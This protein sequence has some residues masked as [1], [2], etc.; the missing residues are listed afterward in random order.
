MTTIDR[1]IAQ[2]MA[3]ASLLLITAGSAFA[4]DWPMWRYDAYRSSNS[5]DSLPDDMTLLWSRRLPKP[6]PAW[7]P[8]QGK[9]QFDASYQPIILGKRLIVPSMISDS[10]TA[11]DTTTGESRWRF[12]ADGPVR[13]APVG[14]EGKVWFASDDGCLYCLDAETGELRWKHRGAPASNRILGNDRMISAWPARGA[15][16]LRAGTIYYAAGIWPFMGTFLYAL[17][18]ETGEEVWCNSGSGSTFQTQQHSSPAFSGVAPQGY[19]VATE[20][21]LL[22]SGGRT[23]PAGYDRATGAFLH[24]DVSSRTFGKDAGGFDVMATDRW[25]YNRD[26]MFETESG[27]LRYRIRPSVLTPEGLF[28]REGKLLRLIGYDPVQETYTDRKGNEKTREQVQPIWEHELDAPITRIHFQAGEHLYAEGKDGGLYALSV[29]KRKPQV[30]WQSRIEG[31]PWTMLAGDDKLVVVTHGGALHC[32]GQGDGDDPRTYEATEPTIPEDIAQGDG[33]DQLDDLL[34]SELPREGYALVLGAN[35][36]GLIAALL[37]HSDYHTLVLDTRT[38]DVDNLRRR[39]DDAG[40]YGHRLHVLPDDIFSAALPPYFADLVLVPEVDFQDRLYAEPLVER[41]YETLRPYGGRALFLGDAQALQPRIADA[42]AAEL[43]SSVRIAP[44]EN[45]IELVRVGALAGAGTWTH[46]Y[47]D[48]ANSVVS[49]DTRVRAPLGLLWFGGPSNQEILPRH[50]HGPTPQVVGGRLFIE[51]P[52]V[53]RAV[54]VYTGRRLWEKKMPGIGRHYDYTSHEPGANAI[55]SNYVSVSDGVYIVQDKTCSR[56]DPATGTTVRTFQLPPDPETG[57]IPDWGYIAVVDD[58]LLAGARPMSFWTP[59][60]D[61]EEFRHV[62]VE[63]V[64]EVVA[65]MGKLQNFNILAK[66]DGEEN[67]DFLVKNLNRLLEEEDLASIL[68]ADLVK[69]KG[70][71][72]KHGQKTNR[73]RHEIQRVV[74]SEQPDRLE[75]LKE[76]NR[77]LLQHVYPLPRKDKP[78]IGKFNL[79]RTA[80]KRLIVMNRHDGQVLWEFDADHALRHNAI[81]AGGGKVFCIDRLPD[82][83]IDSLKRRGLDVPKDARVIALDLADGREVWSTWENVFGTWLGYSAEHDVLIQAGAKGRDRLHDEVGRGMVAYDA[84]TGNELWSDPRE[85]GGPVMLYHDTIITQEKAISLKT[86]QLIRRRHPLTGEAVDWKYNRHYGCATAIGSEHLI[87]FRS[88]A[89]GFFDLTNNGG[90]GNIGGFKAGCTS[91]L[92]VA[93]G[94]LNAPDYTRTCT[95][96]YQNQASL[97]LVHDPSVEVWTFSDL[98]R[99]ESRVK[100]LGLNLG[101]PGDRMSDEGTLWLDLPSTG[102]SSPDVPVTVQPENVHWYRHHA[103]RFYGQVPAW[104]VA[105]GVEGAESF[106]ITL[107]PENDAPQTYTVRLLF[108]EPDPA[109]KVG[110]RIFHVDVMSERR[111]SNVDILDLADAPRRGIAL[112][113]PEL[114]LGTTLRIEL[115]SAEGSDR[116]PLICGIEAMAL[117]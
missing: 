97:A 60:F 9:L 92:I 98:P 73:I 32:F 72:D 78:S 103:S 63:E 76:L 69:V 114:K 13:F 83:Y 91:N 82:P 5:P 34:R 101:A 3:I 38:Q 105:S 27:K 88:A 28:Q 29:E 8:D 54:D 100:R 49:T 61:F 95:C 57:D 16:V 90:T 12:Y 11:Y 36:P 15:P 96:S 86:G 89:A 31:R 59:E 35:R 117:R 106:E 58:L 43:S 4:G 65:E 84:S 42:V 10:L 25:F 14:S 70:S 115:H 51:G 68:P 50:G 26:V 1:Q 6:Q 30:A 19:M 87:T 55:G 17:N 81:A 108:A 41:V 18:A 104:I 2:W 94:V 110:E 48:A 112:E 56:L 24:Y 22:V 74:A 23:V 21:V 79:E 64:S 45:G 116:P 109:C 113:V 33:G 99:P 80:S 75:R 40:L 66:R 39:F 85:Y 71:D 67:E 37:E 47:G 44:R 52:N 77:R 62:K 111:F 53:L 7:P 20:K 46:Q 102:G 93:D 107:A